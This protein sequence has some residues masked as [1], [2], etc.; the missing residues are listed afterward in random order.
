MS[1]SKNISIMI[2]NRSKTIVSH[3]I[4]AKIVLWLGVT[5]TWRTVLK[6]HSI[7]KVENH[8]SRVP[9]T[10]KICFLF[11]TKQGIQKPM[12]WYEHCLWVCLSTTGLTAFF[13]WDLKVQGHYFHIPT[14]LVGMDEGG[15]FLSLYLCSCSVVSC[16]AGSP[17][18]WSNFSHWSSSPWENILSISVRS[19]RLTRL[20][21]KLKLLK[22]VFQALV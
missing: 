6:D 11:S 2:H 1:I 16:P 21:L 8:F 19:I 7:R 14:V 18:Q 12:A 13:F 22:S 4:A 20:F 9:C 17:A 10:L 3:E 5:T 15:P